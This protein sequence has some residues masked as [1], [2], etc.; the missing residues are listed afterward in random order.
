[1]NH[2]PRPSARAHA[3]TLIELLVV[4]SIIALLIGILLPALGAARKV[5]RDAVCLSNIRQINTAC[6]SYA[7][8][9][10]DYYPAASMDPDTTDSLT[11]FTFPGTPDVKRVRRWTSLL[12][13]DNYMPKENGFIC[14]SFDERELDESEMISTADEENYL[15]NNW[16]NLDYSANGHILGGRH[17]SGTAVYDQPARVEEIVQ[18]TETVLLMDGFIPAADPLNTVVTHNPGIRQRAWFNIFATAGTFSETP[19]PRHSNTAVNIAWID[20]HSAPEQF[21]DKYEWEE[22]LPGWSMTEEN[23]WDRKLGFTIPQL[24]RAPRGR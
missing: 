23:K 24:Y 9:N 20:G 5:A 8:D 18:P 16:H 14:P 10:Q 4:I 3:F 21:S 17:A 1:M 15:D 13:A 2:Q 11:S 12:V 6:L 7:A 22:T 19:H